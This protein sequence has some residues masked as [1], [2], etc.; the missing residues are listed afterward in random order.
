[1]LPNPTEGA[2]SR[3]ADIPPSLRGL[4]S[5]NETEVAQPGLAFRPQA[6]NQTKP[7][8][9]SFLPGSLSPAVRRKNA[10]L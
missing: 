1:M 10:F 2:A 3:L 6:E 4:M 8:W 7:E 9:V 5:D